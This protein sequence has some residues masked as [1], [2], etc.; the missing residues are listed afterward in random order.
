[1]NPAR[2]AGH[3]FAMVIVDEL[4][5]HG[6]TDAVLAPGS[7][8][9]PIALAL[10][11][12]DRVRVHVR[13]DERSAAYLA[14][15][16]ARITGRVVPVLCTS[17]TAG[18][19]FHGAVM[20]ADLSR[21][22]LLAMTADRPPSLRGTGAN[23]TV[24]QVE[25]FGTAVRRSRDAPLPVAE[26]G[27]VRAWRQ[28]AA[29]AAAHCLGTGVGWVPGP[30][31]L[32]LPLDEPLLPVDDGVGFPYD[33]GAHDASASTPSIQDA[34]SLD[35]PRALHGVRRGVVV[36]GDCPPGMADAALAFAERARCQLTA[37]PHSNARRGPM[38]LRATDAV[39]ADPQFLAGARADLAVVVGRVGL[40]RALL[41]WLAETPHVVVDPYGS[42]WDVT[43][44][45]R[46][47][48]TASAQSLASASVAPADEVWVARW[49]AAA[50]AAGDAFDAVL[51]KSAALSEPLV[52]R[53][54]AAL[55]T[56]DTA[57]VVS[58]SM[59]IRDLDAVMRPRPL[60]I[61]ANRGVSG[62]D[63]F[64]S[65]AQG[66]ALGHPG[67]TV[68]LCGDLSLLHDVNGLLPGPDARPDLTYV[69]INNDG[70]GIFSLLPQGTGVEPAQFEQAFGTPH[71]M[72]LA[73]VASAYQ[74]GYHLVSTVEDLRVA[75]TQPPGGVRI[76]EVR[77]DRHENAAL[78]EELRRA[79]A[80]AVAGLR[81]EFP[82]PT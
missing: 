46:A 65:T 75:L 66:V 29:D 4:V 74:V 38:A 40:S 19:H 32:N 44:T 51:E 33:L 35:L 62:I 57:L 8:S 5:G 2:N 17:G 48:V 53:E 60:R 43:R 54:V 64:V 63:G 1:M 23:Q 68:A 22:P 78:H 76:V 52:A 45:A 81:L 3:A 16:I 37:E 73:D 39:L 31:H 47:V 67:P 49:R 24:D 28:L 77:T 14:L 27:A 56:A 25:L 7:R 9:T 12:D 13:I 80:T 30:V 34:V 50:D 10:L 41:G 55:V 71:G 69:V 59:P 6:M 15:G 36:C 72:V 58:S 26:P 61:V 42:P 18:T 11:A 20:E 70:G 79:A 21:V 82:L